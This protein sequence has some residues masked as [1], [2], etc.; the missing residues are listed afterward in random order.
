MNEIQELATVVRENKTITSLKL[1]DAANGSE[2]LDTLAESLATALSKRKGKITSLDLT[3]NKKLL[4]V[5]GLYNAI[6]TSFILRDI[7]LD[8]IGLSLN[9]VKEL[10]DALKL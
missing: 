6:K 4:P 10:A 7:I 5:G 1:R 9:G 3:N 8:K 2:E